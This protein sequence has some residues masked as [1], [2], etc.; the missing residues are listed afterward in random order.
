MTWQEVVGKIGQAAPLVGSL[1]APGVGT[2]IGGI[3]ALTASALGCEPTEDAITQVISTNPDAVLKLKELEM[4]HGVELQK[5]VLQ[6]EQARLADIQNARQRQ[7]EHEKATGKTDINLYVLAWT[8]ITGFFALTM[9]L[10]YFSHQGMPIN[11]NTGVLFMLLGTL[12]TAFGMVVGYFFGSSLGS[13]IKT[14]I[15]ARAE[16]I[17]PL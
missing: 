2:A 8:I 5:L 10:L 17:K 9:T 7:I 15:L 13:D 11:D 3:V 16:P 12:S 1:I 4:T 6:Q 14:K